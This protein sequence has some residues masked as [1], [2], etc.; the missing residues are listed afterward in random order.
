MAPRLSPVQYYRP[1]L[2]AVRFLA[3]LLVFLH[4][5][6]PAGRDPRVVHLLRGL[7][8]DLDSVTD[9][10]GFGL[11]LFFTLSAF[12][13][14]ELLLRER[15]SAGTVKVKQ[16]YIRRVLR[17]WPL[18]YL[19]VALGLGA[20]FLPGVDRSSAAQMGWYAIFMGAWISTVQGVVRNPAGLLWSISVE[21]QFYLFAPWMVKYLSRKSLYGCSLV[22]ILIANSWLFHLGKVGAVD[23][24]IW[25]NSVVQFECFAGGILLCLVLRGRLPRLAV[26]QR[27]LLFVFSFLCWFYACYGIHSRFG[28]VGEPNPGSWPLIVGYALGALGSVLILV[29][30]MG[31]SS[32]LIPA[33]AI[34]LGRISFGLYVFH[35]FALYLTDRLIVLPVAQF[36]GHLINSLKGPIYLASL[37][38]ALGLTILIASV[39]YRYFETPFLKMKKRLEIVKTEPV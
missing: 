1:E 13:I 5:T 10:C 35:E 21:E 27:T 2:D 22:I 34:Y 36:K 14:C 20:A 23:F 30:F 37:G 4:H 19:G 7:A 12:L 8:P 28:S 25:F 33:W 15:D 17:I 18:Y 24:A 29:S 3:F 26:W 38:V 39:S 9:A 6:L 32:K 16:F 11:S 31:V